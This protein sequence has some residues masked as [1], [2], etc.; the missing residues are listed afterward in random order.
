V[1]VTSPTVRRAAVAGTFYPVSP[2]ELAAL[3]DSLLAGARALRFPAL[4]PKALVAPHA[5]YVYSGPI[6]GTAYAAL[7]AAASRIR[8]VVL[9]GPAHRARVRGLALPGVQAFRT[10]LGDV[11]LDER[12]LASI[13]ALPQVSTSTLA[14]AQEHSL[15]VQL[16]FLQ[17]VL[18]DFSLVPLVVG[19]ASPAEVAEVLEQLWGGEETLLVVSSDLSHYLPHDVAQRLDANTARRLVEGELVEGTDAC[20]AAPVNGL[21][22]AARRHGLRCVELDLRSSGDTAGPRDEVVGYGAFAFYERGASPEEGGL[23]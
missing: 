16:P 14:H 1:V 13:V 6:A 5:G 21:L 22:V 10:P 11:G 3:V 9:L 20:G 23:R 7:S 4:A 18:G 15:E 2:S 8:R 17:R 19:D 12:A